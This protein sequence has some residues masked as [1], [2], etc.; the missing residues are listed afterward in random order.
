MLSRV[1][2]VHVDANTRGRSLQHSLRPYSCI[3]GVRIGRREGKGRG[4]TGG[5]M[6][7]EEGEGTEEAWTK[8]EGKK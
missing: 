3:L 8:K 4:K 2:T 7:Q 1:L 5:D 6:K